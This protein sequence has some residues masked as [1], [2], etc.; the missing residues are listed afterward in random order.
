MTVEEAKN[1]IQESIGAVLEE[2]EDAISFDTLDE[3]KDS[4]FS[5]C[6][7]EEFAEENS[8]WEIV[9][10]LASD[11]LD[12]DKKVEIIEAW[13]QQLEDMTDI[14]VSIDL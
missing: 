14:Q 6:E 4:V 5:S 10:L 2:D 9:D 11:K 7:V 13:V 1:K 8:C 12:N 3:I